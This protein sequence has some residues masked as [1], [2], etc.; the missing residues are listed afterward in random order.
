MQT[1]SDNGTQQTQSP[2][3]TNH[4][5]N[6]L[7]GRAEVIWL[8]VIFLLALLVRLWGLDKGHWGAEY[9]TAAVRSMSMSWHNFFYCAFD[10]AGFISIDK[11]PIALWMQVASVKI[12]GFSP[13]SI[14]LPQILEG[15]A[16]VGLL[17]HLVRRRFSAPTALFAAFF[18]AVT[19]VWVAV[20]RTNNTD[21]CLLFVLM[22]AA[23]ALIKAAEEGS[24]KLLV[25]SMA[26]V[27][28]AFNVKMLAAYVV[29]PVFCGV[30]LICAVKPLRRKV[31]DVLLAIL[32]LIAVSLPWVVAY[33]LTP[34]DARPFVGGSRTNSMFELIAGHNA[35]N[36]F[37]SPLNYQGMQNMQTAP[38][39]PSETEEKRPVYGADATVKSTFRV[40]MSRTF[41]LTPPGPFRLA[42]GHLAAQTLWLFPFALAAIIIAFVRYHSQRKIT[43]REINLFF[44][45]G[46]VLIYV[47]VYS[48][49]GGILHFY[50]LATL[51]PAVA[52]LAGIG[53]MA[54]WN[55]YRRKDRYAWLLPAIFVATV[56]CHILIESGALGLPVSTF[57]NPPVSWLKT[58]HYT[59]IW[60]TLISVILLLWIYFLKKT[61]RI[62]LV[63]A[64]IAL[65]F[66][67]ASMMILP[68]AWTASSVLTPGIGLIPSADLYRLIAFTDQ[69][70]TS[71]RYVL[72]NSRTNEKLIELLKA[73]HQGERF[74]LMTSTAE[75]AAPIIIETGEAVLARGGFHGIDPT[76][77]QESLKRLVQTG[78]LRFVMLGD[79]TTISRR[80]GS[81]AN[82]KLQD[83]WV[84][85]N[86]I[87]V[88]P[89]LWQSARH[90]YRRMELYDLKAVQE[91]T[92]LLSS[93]LP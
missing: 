71:L 1:T 26:L 49:L 37:F 34:A 4:K 67:L 6:F 58:V 25:L 45:T 38:S 65:V 29:L 93:T 74:L 28:L 81:T 73:N 12:F 10:P 3:K 68:A 78:S 82:G 72:K 53:L 36:R 62:T 89:S 91:R 18:L 20:N 22:L 88:E 21:S 90:K 64:K 43:A 39:N 61:G 32:V 69:N 50:Y 75:L 30:Y 41:V 47:I 63:L 2:G 51:A 57:L 13:G 14:F 70:A 33:E 35:F 11:P 24:H 5:N 16:S 19:P 59:L 77:T 31:T 85:A 7:G 48:S 66:G 40:L 42:S 56:V 84:R 44:W 92:T 87:L 17:Y 55:R 83:D 76:L 52:A 60:G 86:G 8:V 46:W 23:W 27:G 80:M 15:I 54:L 79:E 9:Y